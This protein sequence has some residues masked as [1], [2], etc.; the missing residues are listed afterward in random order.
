MEPVTIGLVLSAFNALDTAFDWG[1]KEGSKAI[2][3]KIVTDAFDHTV[4]ETRS[5]I[6]S[7]TEQFHGNHDLLKVLRLSMLQA[8]GMVCAAMKEKKE[9]KKFRA[10]LQIW[11]DKQSTEDALNNIDA[12]MEWNNPVST[13]LETLFITQQQYADRKEI[14]TA[15]MVGQ[16][17]AYLK[18]EL[19]CELP[20]AFSDKFYIGFEEKGKQLK[21]ENAVAVLFAE[22]LRNGK[23]P[24]G[25]RA[26]K[27]FTHNFLAEI[28]MQLSAV[29]GDVSD[30][31]ATVTRIEERINN[32]YTYVLQG[33]PDSDTILSLQRQ[34]EKQTEINLAVVKEYEHLR[35][36]ITYERG[37][38]ERYRQEGEKLRA[39]K[40]EMAAEIKTL[41]SMNRVDPEKY[42]E[43]TERIKL[44]DEHI[45][46]HPEL[47]P[48]DY[49]ALK[50]KR[51]AEEHYTVTEKAY[52]QA[53]IKA[54][55]LKIK[56]AEAA[57]IYAIKLEDG[58]NYPLA[59]EKYRKAAAL[60]PQNPIYLN[61]LGYFLLHMALYNEAISHLEQAIKNL[62]NH[63]TP[64]EIE[65]AILNNIGQA[66]KQ[67]GEYDKALSYYEKALAIGKKLYG[68][69]HPDIA[70]RY[71]NMGLAYD[72]K[73]EYDK[74]I[75]Y[76]EKALTID[77]KFNGEE[78]PKIATYYN[79]IGL[80]YDSKGEYDKAISYYE[81]ALAIDKKFNGE[82]HPDIA[83]DYSNMG[84]AYDSKGEYDKA[85]SYYEKA[86]A[87][88]K[89][90]Y[91]DEH[92]NIA[93]DYNNMGSA[94]LSK[95]EYDK[96]IS[97]YEKALS[98]FIKFLGE[99]HP[100]TETVR[101]NLESA[102][103]KL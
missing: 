70:T 14:I 22:T 37:E 97:Y 88:G 16:W 61:G 74:A 79:N 72:S 17:M 93:R 29:Q 38:K 54:D 98:I 67:K 63:N 41:I 13:E 11:I 68:D 49:E 10:D 53:I 48:E 85:I 7:R 62:S 50:A 2:F 45:A 46:A 83:I 101:K 58:L 95:G 60:Q 59:L 76:Y 102:R 51:T 71:N 52:K 32:L 23:T 36:D 43:L 12:W 8:T 24:L 9:D 31:K 66:W 75:S 19:K 100:S 30:V 65:G 44:F 4:K 15:R 94:Y 25:Q 77:K 5:I 86:L 64:E 103:S 69:K 73:G 39:E 20:K 80:A 82:E 26:D 28:K 81:K 92:P 89:K 1:I 96:A 78:H 90:L 27:A 91:G 42:N 56:H 84:G 99:N 40:D 3:G 47:F 87:I 18:T 6:A 55:D 33:L 57:F 35:A 34:S 21:W